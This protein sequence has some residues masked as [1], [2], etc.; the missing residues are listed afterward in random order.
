MTS[1]STT[2]TFAPA[3]IG[4]GAGAVFDVS[5]GGVTFSVPLT[6]DVG[7]GLVAVDVGSGSGTLTGPAGIDCAPGGVGTCSAVIGGAGAT[8]TITAT[9]GAG[10][11]LEQWNTD[12]TD[13]CPPATSCTEPLSCDGISIAAVFAP[14]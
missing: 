12:G 2:G 10:F 4:D 9:P 14:G 7:G 3:S 1:C 5:S 6:G 11:Q 13:A 8:V